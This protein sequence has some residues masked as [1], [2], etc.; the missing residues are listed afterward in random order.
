MVLRRLSFLGALILST[1]LSGCGGGGS[2]PAAVSPET[3]QVVEATD[4]NVD[5]KLAPILKVK[6]TAVYDVLF[7]IREGARPEGVHVLV[8]GVTFSES[9]QQFLEGAKKLIRWKFNGTPKGNEVPV[10][11]TFATT[12]AE[13]ESG[14]APKT[15]NRV[16]LVNGQPGKFTI[17]RK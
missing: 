6:Q 3:A 10:A 13:E 17:S 9:S 4:G 7:N 11:L 8:S 1:A 16:Y 15:V 5:P 14:Q 12:D 2:Q